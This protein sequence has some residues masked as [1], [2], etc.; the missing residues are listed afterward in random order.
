MEN[1]P[2]LGRALG[3]RTHRVD[4]AM[5]TPEAASNVSL[6]TQKCVAK[7]SCKPP[8]RRSSLLVSSRGYDT[9]MPSF[10]GVARDVDGVVE[11]WRASLVTEWA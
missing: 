2:A 9:T 1:N 8:E 4:P 7:E 11:R 3:A 10:L 6:T 5:P